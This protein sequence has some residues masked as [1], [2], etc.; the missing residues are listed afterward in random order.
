MFNV[1]IRVA[2]VVGKAHNTAFS[3]SVNEFVSA[4]GHAV[5]VSMCRVCDCDALLARRLA[6]DLSAILGNQLPARNCDIC[7][8]AKA[9]LISALRIIL[10]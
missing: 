7:C 3:A 2:A 4:S 5:K 9:A 10:P 6:N 8:K 1:A